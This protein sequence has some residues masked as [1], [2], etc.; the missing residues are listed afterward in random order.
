MV[1]NDT[2][3]RCQPLVA[4]G[5]ISL[6][7]GNG[8]NYMGGKQS[9]NGQKNGRI[10]TTSGPSTRRA[11]GRQ[12]CAGGNACRGDSSVCKYV[13]ETRDGDSGGLG[14]VLRICF[15]VA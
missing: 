14:R 9:T 7:M 3:A 2:R 11:M 12:P 4:N 8:S 15:S 6:M 1:A 13:S 10:P 5:R